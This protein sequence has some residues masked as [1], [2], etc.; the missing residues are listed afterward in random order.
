M[1]LAYEIEYEQIWDVHGVNEKLSF[2]AFLSF[3][4]CQYPFLDPS[5]ENTAVFH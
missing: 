2:I 1:N 5:I 4:A 3:S